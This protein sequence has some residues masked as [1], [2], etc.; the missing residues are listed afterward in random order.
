[1]N[2]FLFLSLGL[3]GKAELENNEGCSGIEMSDVLRREI[4][5]SRFTIIVPD[6]FGKRATCH[7][8]KGAPNLAEFN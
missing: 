5:S 7:D 1:M 8:T 4:K 2:P 6:H 3:L